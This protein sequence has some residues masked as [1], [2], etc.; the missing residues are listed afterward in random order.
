MYKDLL[1]IPLWSAEINGKFFHRIRDF[2]DD[3]KCGFCV[4]VCENLLK[5]KSKGNIVSAEVILIYATQHYFNDVSTNE[6]KAKVYY[7]LGKIYEYY[8]EDFIKAYTAYEKYTLNTE[9]DGTHSLL[10][11]ALILRDGFVFSD[12][13]EKHYRYCLGETDLGLRNDRFYEALASYIISTHY[14]K[15]EEAEKMKK[16]LKGILKGDELFFLDFFIRKDNIPD[17]L[18]VPEKVIKYV[19]SL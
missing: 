11:K 10:M 6:S 18:T 2:S 16:R 15:D 14:G 7:L 13:L 19:N 17:S 4:D 1:K 9:N 12:E 8:L 3:E 5:R